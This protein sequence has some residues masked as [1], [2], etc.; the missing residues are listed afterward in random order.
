MGLLDGLSKMGVKSINTS[1]MYEDKKNVPEKKEQEIKAIPVIEEKDYIFEKGYE[2]HICDYKFK[3]LTM[4]SNKARLVSLDK[5]LRP[6]FDGVEPLKYEA[7]CCP[8]CGYSVMS[9]YLA[10]LTPSQKKSIIDSVA[11]DF[12]GIKEEKETATYEGAVER[13][14]LALACAIL[15]RAKASEKAYICLKGGW[16][17]RAYAENESITNPTN[18][19]K[20]RAIKEDEKEFLDNAYEGFIQARQSENFPIAGMD[21]TTLDYLIACMACE[22]GIYDVSSKMIASILQNPNASSKIKDKARALK[23]ELL[24]KLKEKG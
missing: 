6:I 19:D 3:A 5:D 22:R 9:K 7:V 15:K 20:I 11:M 17:C 10:P 18:V 24:V 21:A 14:K 4:K 8:Q 12:K 2:C 13:V 1:Q 23:E 16:L